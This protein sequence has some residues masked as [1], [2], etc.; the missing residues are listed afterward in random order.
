MKN[1][2]QLLKLIVP[3]AQASFCEREYGFYDPNLLTSILYER[4]GNIRSMK[5]KSVIC[6][7]ELIINHLYNNIK[8]S[9][10][11]KNYYINDQ[12][13]T[14]DDSYRVRVDVSRF[15]NGAKLSKQEIDESIKAVAKKNKFNPLQDYFTN[16]PKTETNFLDNWLVSVC[17]AQD[18]DANRMIGKKWIISCIARAMNPGCYIEGS[19]ILFGA[20]AAGKTWLLTNLNPKKEYYSGDDVDISNT[21]KSCQTYQGKFIIEFAELA[22]ISKANLEQTKG[23]LTR[24]DDTYVPKFSNF[25]ITE[26]RQMVFSGST[27]NH[28]ILNDTT[29]NRRFWCVKVSKI[30]QELFLSIKESLW[31]EAF[32]AFN[33]GESWTLN[34][35]ER[36]LLQTANSQFEVDDPLATYMAEQL[37]N[38]TMDCDKKMSAAK[39]LEIAKKYDP[40]VHTM[41][42]SKIMVKLG[43]EPVQFTN[44]E[45]KGHRC[46]IRPEQISK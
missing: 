22:N 13:L 29:G 25:S 36:K 39:L 19:L 11:D 31:R 2:I 26:P 24:T 38:Y 9:T 41:T 32:D 20:Q 3:D 45:L 46:Y 7:Y 28:N 12:M 33:N 6:N 35:D 40:K 21:Q 4:N 5:I 34:E 27:N 44:G 17:G 8:Y 30:N 23:Y 43:W 16:L 18:N 15:L 37:A 10:F 42:M 1:D 14:D